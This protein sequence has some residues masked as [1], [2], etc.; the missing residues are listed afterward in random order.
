MG[1]C[2]ERTGADFNVAEDAL[3]YQYR[4]GWIRR[5][6]KTLWAEGGIARLYQ[7]LPFAILQGPLSRF[8]DTAANAHPFLYFGS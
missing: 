1:L 4:F 2:C 7:G 5:A 3:N 6:L 8:G